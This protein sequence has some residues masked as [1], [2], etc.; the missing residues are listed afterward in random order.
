MPVSFSR[1]NTS[2]IFIITYTVLALLF[3]VFNP[4]SLNFNYG[5][6]NGRYE[7]RVDS[8]SEY[9][10]RNTITR[11]LL[12]HEDNSII[13]IITKGYA[14]GDYSY[15]S[16][17]YSKYYS[18]ISLHTIPATLVAKLFHLN[19]ESKLKIYFA[20]LRLANAL[21][22]SYFLCSFCMYFCRTQ[23]IK[24]HFV[25][26]VVVGGSAG[27]IFFS[28]NLYFLSA[29]MLMPAWL[30]AFQCHCGNRFSKLMLFFLGTIFFLRG[31]EFATVFTLLTSFSA[32]IFTEG[33]WRVKI[34]F[35]VIAFGIICLSFIFSALVYVV[36]ISADSGWVL[37]FNES[38]HKAFASMKHRT[39]S[40]DGV[41]RPFSPDFFNT[42][43]ERW[44]ATA[45]SLTSGS[46]IISEK[47]V[48]ILV[49]IAAF[50]RPKTISNVDKLIIS[51]GFIGY[52]SWYVFAY[53]HIMWHP[54][55]DWYIFSLTMGISF[56]LLILIYS[57]I[58]FEF[59][60]KLYSS[61]NK[62]NG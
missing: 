33:D 49:A 12:T 32:A 28:Q 3:F 16:D 17:N 13:P 24:S 35:T 6:G 62:Q 19:T 14:N 36:I 26:P 56:S 34:K 8:F 38:A 54:M 25:I 53:Q 46:I 41:P 43:N 31:Y 11:N 60:T 30:I 23:K 15:Y 37:T 40:F 1:N 44:H 39:A 50:L 18:N 52:L 4:Q 22:L 45:F 47:Y 9:I 29:L 57:N 59:V 55:Y 5:D 61:R 42:M 2:V 21:L 51:Y 48:I 7:D 10:V 20:T 58:M 27:L